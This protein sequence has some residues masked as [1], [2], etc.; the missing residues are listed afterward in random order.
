MSNRP[1]PSSISEEIREAKSLLTSVNFVTATTSFL[2]ATYERS[3]YTRVKLTLTFP[4][5]YPSNPLI[6]MV[7][8]NSGG[9]GGGV[10]IPPGLKK[11]IEKELNSLALE[12]A[13]RDGEQESEQIRHVLER[14]ISFINTNLFV[15]CWKELKKCIDLMQPQSTISILSE[16]KGRIRLTLHD[17]AYHYK[18]TI[19]ID[20]AY[21][22]YS[23]ATGGKSC[24]LQVQSSNFPSYIENMITTQAQE[25]VLRMQSGQSYDRALVLSNPTK[26][27]N[28]TELN[29]KEQCDSEKHNNSIK[30]KKEETEQEWKVEESNRLAVY[31]DGLSY[32][33]TI[34]PQPSLLSLVSFLIREVQRLVS[35]TCPGCNERVLPSN[36]EELSSSQFK[37]KMQPMRTYCG[38]WYHK[39]C[40]HTIL[41]EPPFGLVE[42]PTVDCDGQRIYHPNWST[43]TKQLEKEWTAKQARL[44]EIEDTMSFF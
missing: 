28:E 13:R 4:D 27:P 26:A 10:I 9:G 35:H 6:A 43:D 41:T 12:K 19:T 16:S 11:K 38:C 31:Y 3:P 36:P 1:S 44:R 29:T 25:I 18:C 20:P 34:T 24:L 21:P 37:S 32:G 8:S 23:A 33:G 22:D 42:C 17:A 39:S 2:V 30:P 40:L 15:P 5:G 7:E 14:L